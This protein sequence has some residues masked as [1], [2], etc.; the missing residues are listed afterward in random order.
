MHVITRRTGGGGNRFPA[1]AT[2]S[3]GMQAMTSNTNS[4]F[5]DEFAGRV[6]SRKSKQLGPV[7]EAIAAMGRE[8]EPPRRDALKTMAAALVGTV[9]G[10]PAV[11][12][13]GP[14]LSFVAQEWLRDARAIGMVL[15]LQP[16]GHIWRTTT[17]G[18]SIERHKARERLWATL[19]KR[20]R[21]LE[22]VLEQVEQGFWPELRA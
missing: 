20:P 3:T 5:V 12:A 17:I 22:A 13:N 19:N 6:H 10:V 2:A 7:T 21:L 15:I 1:L 9:F 14:D 18:D 8:P 4:T 16:D 11:R